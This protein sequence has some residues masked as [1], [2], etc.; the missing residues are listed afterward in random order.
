MSEKEIYR[1]LDRLPSFTPGAKNDRR[2]AQLTMARLLILLAIAYL[3]ALLQSTMASAIFPNFMKPDL[4]LI[5]ITYLGT[6]LPLMPGSIL[7]LFCGL[8]YDTFSGSPFGLFLFIHL[9][10]LFLIKLL[11]KFLIMGETITFRTTLVALSMGVQS[12]LL[13]FLPP[14]LGIH[15][16]WS[17]PPP[18]WIL[19]QVLITGAL[20]WPFFYLFKKLDTFPRVETSQATQS[21]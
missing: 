5:F 7:T 14:A 4:I 1:I 21:L 8:L 6:S 20:C 15:N 18:G 16:H 12:L 10:V 2:T 13:I 19:P 3:L 11:A 9:S 17:L